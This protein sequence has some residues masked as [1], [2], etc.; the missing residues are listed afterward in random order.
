MKV[1]RSI[2]IIAAVF[3]ASLSMV[4]AQTITVA[5]DTNFP[6]FEFKGEGGKY[7]GFDIELWDAIAS[8]IGLD[9]KLQPM[10]FNGIIPGLQTGQLDV[11]IAGMTIKPE[12]V[13]VVDFSEG[14]Y[15]AGLLILVRAEETKIKNLADLN[16]KIIATKLGTTSAD[17][18][19]EQVKQAKEVKL[20]PNND[21][22]FLELISGG[23]DAVV[24]DSPVIS[25]F[26]RKTGKGQAKVVGDLYKGQSYGIAFPKGSK[27]RSKVNDALT[28]LRKNGTYAELYR[29]WF[30]AEPK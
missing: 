25:D 6:P 2:V 9:Y 5:T 24:F 20:Y 30:G 23:A 27:L 4:N 22:L 18:V 19:A 3:V 14:Y 7:T 26:L 10:D 21:A 8:Q 16:G 29:K 1:I 17:F 13:K 11:G 15:N 28:E 12:R